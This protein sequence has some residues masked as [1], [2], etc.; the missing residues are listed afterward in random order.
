MKISYR[1]DR[2]R[3]LALSIVGVLV[4]AAVLTPWPG[5]SVPLWCAVLVNVVVLLVVAPRGRA[6]WPWLAMIPFWTASVVPAP[7]PPN[8]EIVAAEFD[9]ECQRMLDLAKAVSSDGEILGLVMGTGEALDPDRPFR[10]LRRIAVGEPDATVFLADER[11]RIV[12]WAGRSDRLPE[13]FRLLGDRRWELARTARTV[14]VV[15]REPLFQEGRLAGSVVVFERSERTVRNGFGIRAPVGWRIRFCPGPRETEYIIESPSAPGLELPIAWERTGTGYRTILAGVGWILIFLV[16]VAS[17]PGLAAV[18]VLGALSMFS[19]SNSMM[20]FLIILEGVALGRWIAGMSLKTAG[21][22]VGPVVGL[23]A[24]GAILASSG[25][26]AGGWLPE[27]LLAPG[28]GV[29]FLIAGAW[30]V[31]S[32][33]IRHWGLERRLAAAFVLATLAA[34]VSI[35]RPAVELVRWP[36]FADSGFSVP[37]APILEL[38]ERFGGH[39]PE[40]D[41]GDLGTMLAEEWGLDRYAGG[42]EIEVFADDGELVS[43]WGDLGPAGARVEVF[44]QW[45]TDIGGVDRVRL[46]V[47]AEPWSLLRDWPTGG[48][49]DSARQSMIWWVVLSRSGVV[50]ATLHPDVVPLGPERAGELYFRR[51][52]WTWMEVGGTLR[53]ARI[54]RDHSWL[55]AGVAHVPP[56]STWVVRFLLGIVWVLLAMAVARPPALTGDVTATFGGRLRLLVAGAVVIPL[57]ALALVLQVRISDQEFEADRALGTESFRSIRYTA[58]HLGGDFEVDDQFARWLA[59]GWGGEVLLFEG[60]FPVAESRPD[61]VDIGC[62]P[63]LPVAEAYPSFLLGR[64]DVVVRRVGRETVSAGAVTIADRRMLLEL[65]REG[66]FAARDLPRAI[67]WL[68]GG[69]VVAAFV[70]LALAGRVERRL[71]FSLRELVGVSRRLLDGEPLGVV[72]RPR[73]RDLAEVVEAVERMSHAVR[74]RE[75]TLKQQEELL[76]ITLASLDPAVLVIDDR[77]T[78]V[79]VNPAGEAVLRDFPDE[80]DRCCVGNSGMEM[81]TEMVRPDPGTDLTWR[82][83]TAE[84]PL[85]GD[86]RGRVIV[87]EDVTEVVRADRLQHLTHMARIVAHEV[88]NPL[89]PIRLWVQELQE[90]RRRR[91]GDLESLVDEAAE[92]I[93]AQTERLQETANAFS[94]LVALESWD[95]QDVDLNAIAREAVRHLE[96]LNRVGGALNLL[97]VPPGPHVVRADPRWVRRALDTILLN[98]VTVIDPREGR[99]TVRVGSDENWCFLEVEDDGGGI[100]DSQREDLFAPHFSQTGQGTGLGLAMVRQVVGRAYG[101]VEAFNGPKGLIVRM[102]FPRSGKMSQ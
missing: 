51:G 21:W 101:T 75:A 90:S 91:S 57:A 81:E 7:T 48:G 80:L 88:K 63:G 53:P 12:A 60:A 95:V 79:F 25:P 55:V 5:I 22:I 45:S 9:A 58:E 54:V 77:G 50:A 97:V 19:G 76:R 89:T 98:S 40:I 78:P 44:R 70:A 16:S 26:M 69:A 14:G 43:N 47:P 49:V 46:N 37:D 28:R 52:G 42:A 39:L 73:E 36:E 27:H 59:R 29:V 1:G 18:A 87:I 92:E 38:A 20:G 11:G 35:G 83:G 71:S 6:W 99:I 82:V 68:F 74:E 96:V 15:V 41:L 32:L 61:L 65:F 67:D 23:G 94:N 33:P 34:V 62:L 24:A 2:E 4:A 10:L 64:D 85:P 3:P 13:G 17:A 56:A 72:E 93:L 100:D 86:R 84:V 31:A 30:L 8:P 102:R 66:P